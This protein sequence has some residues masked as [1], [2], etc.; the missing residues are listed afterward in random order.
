[1]K[2]FLV[3]FQLFIAISSSVFGQF[4]L[5]FGPSSFKLIEKGEYDNAE[6]KISKDL[7]KNADNLEANY[8]MGLLSIKRK[9]TKY[10]P[11][12]SYEYLNKSKALFEKITNDNDIKRLNKIPISKESYQNYIDTICRCAM[13][14]A[15]V[16]NDIKIYQ[17]YLK[18]YLASPKTYIAKITE[19]R[20]SLAFLK[21]STANTEEAFNSF[22][23][24]FPDAAQINDATQKR[25]GLAFEKAKI[26][27]KIE[28]YEEFVKKYP[29]AKEVIPAKDR[30]CEL[31]YNQAEKENNTQSYKKFIDSY[32]NSKQ[33]E[34]ASSLYEKYF[35]YDYTSNSGWKKYQSYIENYPKSLMIPVAHDSI[36]ALGTRSENLEALLYCYEN[37]TGSKKT[38]ALLKYYEI[39]TTDGEKQTLDMFYSKFNDE[40][41][42]DVKLM[43]YKLA[44]LGDELKLQLPYM[45]DNFL[46]YDE[47]IRLAAPRERAYTALQKVISAD[48]ANKDWRSAIIK[49][50][51]YM[52]YFGNKNKK[53]I[54]LISF[55]ESQSKKTEPTPTK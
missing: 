32:P 37:L 45:S 48:I 3:V 21:A 31:A 34:K 44:A 53:I 16:K 33:F 28:A 1:M 4:I 38:N 8:A 30:I 20:N 25:N 14:D 29:G 46:K 19:N 7:L 13:E 43:D 51:T 5:D 11:E 42:K 10:S 40:T 12:K 41:L 26:T 17:D 9:Y 35:F 49:L 52:G 27:D 23:S 6:K 24:D 50:K 2:K 22:I 55:F 47:Y 15:I 36:L 18:Y 54:D 39:F